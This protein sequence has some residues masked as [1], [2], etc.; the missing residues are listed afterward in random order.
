V[1][2]EYVLVNAVSFACEFQDTSNTDTALINFKLNCPRSVV[3]L[4]PALKSFTQSLAAKF[5]FP[6]GAFNF[7]IHNIELVLGKSTLQWVDK[8]TNQ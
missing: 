7:E 3:Q 2:E 6:I 1:S 4:S 5:E 8:S